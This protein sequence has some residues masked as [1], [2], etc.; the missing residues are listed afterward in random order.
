MNDNVIKRN[1][2]LKSVLTRL[3]KGRILDAGAGELR[4]K[5]HCAHLD[6]VSQ[7][8]CQYDGKGDGSALQQSDNDWDTSRI[9][10][11]S[12]IAEIPVEDAGFEYVLCSEVFEHIPY[13]VKAL[14]EFYRVLKPGGMVILTA[15]FCSLTH[16]APYHM[17]SGFNR[18]W[19]EKVMSDI[20]FVEIS[21]EANGNWFDYMAQEVR[22]LPSMAKKYSG[23]NRLMVFLYKV[24]VLPM[25]MLLSF[26]NKKENRSD[27]LLCYGYHVVARKSEQ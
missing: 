18:Y 9:D 23:S 12:D 22:R 6:Y 5:E 21:I 27:D 25:L 24:S 11:V 10:I 3:P 19:Y 2:W 14:E 7:D 26:L 16:M 15:P 4:N 20:G 8:F 17:Y 13:P 1:H